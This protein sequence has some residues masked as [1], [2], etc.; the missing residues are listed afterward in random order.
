MPNCKII[1]LTLR[2]ETQKENCPVTRTVWTVEG[3]VLT[4]CGNKYSVT[5]ALKGWDADSDNKPDSDLV[6]I[7][8]K[9]YNVANCTYDVRL[10][11]QL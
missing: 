9:T 4:I 10:R 11:I 3:A 1:Q 5:G 8:C 6:K 7:N 2:D